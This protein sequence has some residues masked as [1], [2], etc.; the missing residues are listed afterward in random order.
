MAQALLG[1]LSEGS[2]GEV[3]DS[4]AKICCCELI[5]RRLVPFATFRS[6][7]RAQAHGAGQTPLAARSNPSGPAPEAR[8]PSEGAHVVVLCSSSA[9]VVS[10]LCRSEQQQQQR[11]E[12]AAAPSNRRRARAGETFQ[13][14][15]GRCSAQLAQNSPAGRPTLSPQAAKFLI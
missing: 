15:A 5:S 8:A 11:E 14:R 4:S 6:A 2:S 1:E 7:G 13:S 10:G 3:V 12:V 9:R